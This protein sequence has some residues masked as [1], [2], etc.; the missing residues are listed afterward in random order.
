MDKKSNDELKKLKR[1]FFE[2]ERTHAEEKECL[3]GVINVFSAVASLNSEF[4]QEC[5]TIKQ[6][7]GKDEKY[8]LTEIKEQSAKLKKKLF[9]Y[10]TEAATDQEDTEEQDRLYERLL[11]ACRIIRR[12]MEAILDDFYPVSSDLKEKASSIK[13]KCH[14]EIAEAE[15]EEPAK[16][17]LSFVNRLKE[18]ISD[19]FRYANKSFFTL[20]KELKGLEEMLASEFD[21]GAR[22]K[23]IEQFEMKVNEE[24]GS[25]ADSFSIH[26]TIN[27]IKNAVVKKLSN[28][29]E[30]VARKKKDEATRAKDAQEKIGE[31]KKRI[32][33]AEKD[34]R[35]IAK[36]A[37][38]FQK[39]AAR[40][41]LTNL[42]N[43]QAF[44]L[45]LKD[46]Q[47]A[48]NKTGEAFLLII[49]DVD[50]LKVIND[51]H[52]HIS[53]DKVLKVVAQCLRETFREVDFIARYGGDEF[54]VI[55]EGLSLK[56]GQERTFVFSEKL[57]KKRFVTRTT[58]IRIEISASAGISEAKTG[59]S[60]EEL[61]HR[62]D[63]AM[64]DLKK[65]RREGGKS[66][67]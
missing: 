7:L 2:T 9:A 40:D 24:V 15:L 5:Q 33:D 44:D 26:A 57:R 67:E 38:H 43:R 45:K 62:A 53:G 25:I 34:I 61:I 3:L 39:T 46:T 16:A 49:F 20:F 17:F 55:V 60:P 6:I 54:A 32:D 11:T 58:K 8:P 1:E 47:E 36:K 59:E 30:L 35:K 52:G 56:K 63:T 29:K 31:L 64:Y 18:K 14:A 10:E 4:S 65:K 41:G 19:D 21:G 23:E 27:D 22:M 13:I 48:L 28:I 37:V 66:R 51:V 12:I 42:Y 50:R